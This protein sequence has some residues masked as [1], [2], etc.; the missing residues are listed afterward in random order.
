M[1]RMN[2]PKQ[3]LVS[4]LVSDLKYHYKG[5][6]RTLPGVVTYRALYFGLYDA[7]M[8]EIDHVGLGLKFGVAYGSTLM[9]YLW[10]TPFHIVATRMNLQEYQ[11]RKYRNSWHCLSRIIKE[12]GI[13]G[14]FKGGF[15]GARSVTSTL[16]LVLYDQLTDILNVIS[17]HN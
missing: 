15:R 12:E 7:T 11:T 3:P 10:S 4:R 9:A 1:S 16:A 5:F 8:R 6:G 14:L 2:R 13:G 17:K